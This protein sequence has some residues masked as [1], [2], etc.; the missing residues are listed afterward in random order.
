M[1][2]AVYV[3]YWLD[4][5]LLEEEDAGEIAR[6]KGLRIGYVA[7]DPE[8]DPAATAEETVVA[9]LAADRVDAT[10]RPGRAA[11]ALRRIGF[12]DPRRPVETLSGGWKK[13]LAI[14]RE[15]AREPDLLL[16]DEPTNHLDLEGILALEA[17]LAAPPSPSWW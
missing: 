11:K 15:L 13:R 3:L 1:V 6:R 16:L 14:A 8:L 17:L 5:V 2:V 7:Q 10:Q 4:Y 12:A 9:A